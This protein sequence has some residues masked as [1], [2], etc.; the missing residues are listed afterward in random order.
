[1]E[2]RFINAFNTRPKLKGYKHAKESYLKRIRWAVSLFYFGMGLCFA[3]WASRIPDIKAS[4]HLSESDLGSILFALPFGQLMIMPFSGK[5]VTK[6]GSHKILLIALALYAIALTNLGLAEKP[7]QLSLGLFLFGI[8]GNL[9]NIAVNTQGVY[10]EGLFKRTIMSSFHGAWSTAGFSGALIGIVMLAL[11]LSPFQ[12][13]V[14]AALIVF[15]LIAANY[16]YLIRAKEKK[17][18]EK[19]KFFAKPDGV[20]LWLGI[21]GFCCMASEGVMFDWSGVYFKEIVKAPGPL[22]ILGYTSFM[23]MMAS[24]RFLG[25]RLIHKYGRKRVLQISGLLI[26][27]G[28]FTSVFLPYLIPSTLAFMLVGL[29]VSTIVPTVYS[30]A[31][32]NATVAPGEALTIVSSVSFLGFLMGPPVIGFIAEAAGLQFSFAFIGIFGVLIA[33]MASRIKAIQ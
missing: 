6:Y 33:F 9:S 5:L 16:K 22:V 23:I 7:W 1:M 25:D 13:F 30:I 2:F 17:S 19:K 15:V 11:K 31:G 20:L 24:G 32:K 21:I 8:F 14:I 4:L 26:S 18:S 27:T 29:G 3:T 12:H 10:T 28:L